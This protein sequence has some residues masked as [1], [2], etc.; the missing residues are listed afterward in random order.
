MSY[1]FLLPTL[2]VV[3]ALTTGCFTAR[4]PVIH[5]GP[6]RI[7]TDDEIRKADEKITEADKLWAQR[8]DPASI[9]KA[10][11]LLHDSLQLAPHNTQALWRAARGCYWKAERGGL[12]NVVY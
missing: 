10:A 11:G 9:E 8:A 6:D 3:C 12:S 4:T 2:A 7:L 5:L 1:R